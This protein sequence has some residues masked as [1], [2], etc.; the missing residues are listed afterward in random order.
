MAAVSLSAIKL[1]QAIWYALGHRVELSAFLGDP[2]VGLDD[3]P[4]AQPRKHLRA[5]KAV[6][7]SH[8]VGWREAVPTAR[9]D[10]ELRALGSRRP[11]FRRSF[12][13]LR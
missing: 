3:N 5:L 8:D 9:G 4:T 12:N 11:S 7:Q 13:P 2:R 6:G 1:G 10:A